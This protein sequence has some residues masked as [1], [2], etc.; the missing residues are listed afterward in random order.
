MTCIMHVISVIA[1]HFLSTDY[2]SLC[3]RPTLVQITLKPRLSGTRI[4]GRVSKEKSSNF[5]RKIQYG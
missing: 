4:S 2:D 1:A 5:A 3:N